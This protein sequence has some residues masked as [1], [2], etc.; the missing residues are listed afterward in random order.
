MTDHEAL[1]AAHVR[2]VE[3]IWLPGATVVADCGNGGLD[4]LLQRFPKRVDMPLFDRLPQLR[5]FIGR[6][7]GTDATWCG[8]AA[9]LLGAYPGFVFTACVATFVHRTSGPSPSYVDWG[10]TWETWLY[11]ANEAEISPM[12]LAWAARCH[13]TDR[14][15]GREHYGWS[16][17]SPVEQVEGER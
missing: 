15:I 8:D 17:A 4:L 14:L 6:D 12:A 5:A 3:M 16:D 10:N 9:S 1:E 7:Y 11:A 2:I 13:A